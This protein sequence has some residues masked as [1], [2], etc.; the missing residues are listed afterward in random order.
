[1]KS[2]DY[3]PLIKGRCIGDQCIFFIG[4][5]AAIAPGESSP[6]VSGACAILNIYASLSKILEILERLDRKK[7]RR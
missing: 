4:V 7:L 3:C 6:I 1:M 5:T 2:K